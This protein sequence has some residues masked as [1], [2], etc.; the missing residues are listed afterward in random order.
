MTFK[1]VMAD[2][3]FGGG[4]A[5]LLGQPGRRLSARQL[6]VFGRW[7]EELNGRYV[8]A[9]DVGMQVA[10]MRA[11]ART[12]RYV[13]GLGTSGIGGDPSPRTAEGVLV[14]IEAAVRFHLGADSLRD[15]RVAV[16]GLGN[17]GFHL[18]T[19]LTERGARLRVADIDPDRVRRAEQDLGATALGVD[20]VLGT[21]VDVVAPCALGGA[22]NQRTV[23]AL[24]ASIVAG[25]ANNQLASPELGDALAR[26]GI[27]YAPDYVINAGGVISIA[28]EY[29]GM[30]DPAWVNIRIAAIGERLE[31]IFHRARESGLATSRIADQMARERL[32]AAAEH[33][34]Q[35]ANF[36]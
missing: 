4:K 33:P 20:E 8:T 21:D 18:A 2:L 29:L 10:D 6:E 30:R 23:E 19:L 12:T 5:V 22:L 9:E 26:R 34:P 31:A 27:L 7:V 24:R 17:V 13:S 3:P 11:I 14:G 25:A 16:Q 1:N 28:H 32:A 35:V 15:I 36:R